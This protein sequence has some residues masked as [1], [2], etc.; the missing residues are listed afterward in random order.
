MRAINEFSPRAVLLSLMYARLL[1]ARQ[2]L[3]GHELP[4]RASHAGDDASWPEHVA[5]LWCDES[6]LYTEPTTQC[7]CVAA[8]ALLIQGKILARGSRDRL[9]QTIIRVTQK[10]ELEREIWCARKD[11][12]IAT[13]AYSSRARGTQHRTIAAEY[14]SRCGDSPK[15]DELQHERLRP[16]LRRRPKTRPKTRDKNSPCPARHATAY[17]Y[18][19]ALPTGRIYSEAA[20]WSWLRT[21]SLAAPLVTSSSDCTCIDCEF[22]KCRD[23]HVEQAEKINAARTRASRVIK[24]LQKAS[25]EQLGNQLRDASLVVH[26]APTLLVHGLQTKI[27]PRTPTTLCEIKRSNEASRATKGRI[28]DGGDGFGDSRTR[29]CF[30][31]PDARRW[32]C[33]S[34]MTHSRPATAFDSLRRSPRTR[35]PKR[36]SE[37]KPMAEPEEKRPRTAFSAEQ[38]ARLKREFAENKYLTEQRRQT[39]SKELGLNE[40]QIKIW[41][42]NKRAKIKKASG[43]KNPL[44]L[45][46]MAQGLYN[47]STVPLSKEETKVRTNVCRTFAQNSMYF[48]RRVSTFDRDQRLCA[49]RCTRIYSSKSMNY[50]MKFYVILMQ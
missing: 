26:V 24:L 18:S 9:A 4:D 23:S 43:Q 31:R 41:F 19:K 42:Q 12:R 39:L 48:W 15:K 27:T 44:A 3:L 46:L 2:K 33:F 32:S 7:H 16:E 10:C 29:T 35:R 13:F 38:L 37:A 45:Q 30:S 22:C 8:A 36:P 1:G 47:H 25:R 40:A 5:K 49:L 34:L 20:R 11:E 28:V 6:R 14:P 50:L 17:D 21:A